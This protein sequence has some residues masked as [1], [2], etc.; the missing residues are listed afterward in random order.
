M[1]ATAF[2]SSRTMLYELR[3]LPNGLLLVGLALMAVALAMAW[4]SRRSA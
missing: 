2:L 3:T 1:E 4:R